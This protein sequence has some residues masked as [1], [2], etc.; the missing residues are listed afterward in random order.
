MADR[1]NY[2]AAIC[3]EPHS[4]VPL[5]LFDVTL[6]M[7]VADI[8][9][10]SIFSNGFDGILSAR[11]LLAL[12]RLLDTDAVNGSVMWLDAR[13]FGGRVCHPRKGI[14]HIVEPALRT[15]PSR[16]YGL[17]PCAPIGRFSDGQIA[18]YRAVRE[19]CDAALVHHVPSPFGQ[20]ASM[21][22]LEQLL[23]D[24]MLEEGYVNDLLAFSYDVVSALSEAVLKEVEADVSL[25]SGAYDNIDIVGKDMLDRFSTPMLSRLVRLLGED[26]RTCFHPHGVLSS[27]GSSGLLRDYERMGI[28]NL[29]YG[30][31]NDPL[32]IHS[33]IP[34][35][36]LTGGIDTY[37]TIAL[38]DG[39][40]V[41][42]DTIGHLDMM[43]GIDYVFSCSCSV[44]RGLPL[45]RMRT[46]ASAVRHHGML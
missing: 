12:H 40:R 2:M 14:P 31:N 32:A 6:G 35:I 36:S 46:M 1:S 17:D 41:E 23:M 28:D 3:G 13:L 39:E 7:E 18:S 5:Y 15:D 16:L 19:G 38:G 42:K 10:D 21:R 8:D 45:E 27:P 29:Y 11:S 34:N 4:S 43:D 33:E 30:E 26:T 22:G 25:I 44:D 24:L 37:T 20:S 9:T